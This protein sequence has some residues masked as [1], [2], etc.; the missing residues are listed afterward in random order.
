MYSH[1]P[2]T[3][4]YK[5]PTTVTKSL[6]TAVVI[7]QQCIPAMEANPISSYMRIK[8]QSIGNN[9]NSKERLRM[10]IAESQKKRVFKVNWSAL[11]I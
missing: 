11:N 2:Q 7:P 9:E 3:L 8:V 4:S 6:V 10:K 5:R 1:K